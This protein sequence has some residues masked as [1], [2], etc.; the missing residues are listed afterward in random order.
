M[1]EEVMDDDDVVPRHN[2]NRNDRHHN[3]LVD[4]LLLKIYGVHHYDRILCVHHDGI[5]HSTWV[6]IS[7]AADAAAA[8]DGDVVDVVA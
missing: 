5:V 8:D 7:Y 4:L 1:I 6:L 2:H 3:Y